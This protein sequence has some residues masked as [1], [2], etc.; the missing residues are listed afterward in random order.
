MSHP[1]ADGHGAVAGRDCPPRA[2]GG[3]ELCR[4]SPKRAGKYII[5]D[6][7]DGV[8]VEIEPSLIVNATLRWIDITNGALCRRITPPPR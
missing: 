3:A 8:G 7:I 1:R 5:A 6:G 2:G 4:A